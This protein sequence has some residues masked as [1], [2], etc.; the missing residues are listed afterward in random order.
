MPENIAAKDNRRFISYAR[1]RAENISRHD[2]YFIAGMGVV[3]ALLLLP[4]LHNLDAPSLLGRFGIA[5]AWFAAAFVLLAPFGLLA[6]AYMLAMLPFHHSSA[7]QLSRYA[8]I[9][10][11]NVALNASIFNLCILLTGISTGPIVTVFALIT[12]VI[13]V[14][15]SF[16]WSVY[17]TFRNT[18]LSDRQKQY[19]RFVG[20]SSAVATVNIGIIFVM[21]S[22]F[23]A[24]SGIPGP[25]WANIA[26]LCT[27]F[28]ALLGNFMGYKYFVFAHHVHS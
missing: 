25:V 24:P 22:V 17:W 1:A 27:I 12:F 5:Y 28:T 26:L 11:F 19:V 3:I 15:Q 23:G 14:T 2:S 10:C 20:V 18:P 9:G 16:F 6:L 13:V 8:V 21:T 7:A 4:L